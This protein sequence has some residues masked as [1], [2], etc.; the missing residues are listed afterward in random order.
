MYDPI[1]ESFMRQL[2]LT[3]IDDELFGSLALRADTTGRPIEDVA[4]EA[5]ARGLL[6]DVKGRTAVAERIRAMTPRPIE[7]DST[8]LIRRIRDAP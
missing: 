4:R 1:Q 8:A 2:T 6:V 3:D 5:L 7:E